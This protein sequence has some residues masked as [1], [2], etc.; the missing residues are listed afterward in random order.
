[1]Q[2]LALHGPGPCDY[3]ITSEEEHTCGVRQGNAWEPSG[4]R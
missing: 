3:R 1:M 2:T 4:V